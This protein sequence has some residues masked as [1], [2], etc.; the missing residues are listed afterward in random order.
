[1]TKDNRDTSRIL[2]EEDKKTDWPE[3][4]KLSQAYKFLGISFT[5]MTKLVNSG[6]IKF[7][8]SPLDNRVKLVRRADL[9]E[10][11]RQFT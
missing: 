8:R 5:K 9:E 1:M 4:M 7:E 3:K 2:S 11:K 6:V 10:L